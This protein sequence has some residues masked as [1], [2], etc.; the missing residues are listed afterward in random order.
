MRAQVFDGI[1]SINLQTPSIRQ[2]SLKEAITTWHWADEGRV[3]PHFGART[4]APHFQA[5][6]A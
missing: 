1:A 3:R 2:N 4:T 6:V 5:G